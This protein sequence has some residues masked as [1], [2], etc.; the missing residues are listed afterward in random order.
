MEYI[1]FVGLM[2]VCSPNRLA[3]KRKNPDEMSMGFDK[4]GMKRG[5]NGSHSIF[6]EE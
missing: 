3:E 6:G 4:L 5:E 2:V 1:Q